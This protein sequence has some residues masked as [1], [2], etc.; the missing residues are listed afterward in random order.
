M[1]DYDLILAMVFFWASAL[2]IPLIT[3]LDVLYTAPLAMSS[4]YA[5]AKLWQKQRKGYNG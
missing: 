5:A 3:P 1:N 2:V 4:T